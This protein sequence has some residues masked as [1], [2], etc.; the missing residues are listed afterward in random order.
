[1]CKARLV[2]VDP[3]ADI[4]DADDDILDA[5]Q[6]KL[7]VYVHEIDDAIVENQQQLEEAKLK[8]MRAQGTLKYLK[9]LQ[10]RNSDVEIQCPICKQVP[11]QKYAVLECGH[12]LCVVCLVHMQQFSGTFMDCC[13][14]RHKQRFEQ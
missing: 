7:S 1:M 11:S 14:C 8:F 9:H 12:H 13:V 2:A 5:R 6:S 4:D 3:G 10:E